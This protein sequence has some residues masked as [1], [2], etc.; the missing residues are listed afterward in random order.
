MRYLIHLA[1]VFLCTTSQLIYCEKFV[2]F[3]AQSKS[4]IYPILSVARELEKDNHSVTFVLS[5][6]MKAK[7]LKEGVNVSSITAQSLDT[8]DIVEKVGAVLESKA[9]GGKLSAFLNLL[10]AA[11]EQCHYFMVDTDL[12]T[13]LRYEKFDYAIVDYAHILCFEV[14]AYKLSLPFVYIG[15]HIDLAMYRT[16]FFPSFMPAFFS[17]FTDKMTFMERVMNVI[18]HMIHLSKPSM[19]TFDNVVDKYAPERPYLTNQQLRRNA[20]L[21]IIDGDVLMDYPVAIPPNIVLCGGLSASDAKS[22]PSNIQT[23]AESSNGIVIVSF[24]SI[25]KSIPQ[26]VFNKL[27]GSFQEVKQ[28]KFIFRYGNTE[29]LTENVLLLP[30]LPQNDLLGHPKT[31]LFI[32]HCGKSGLFEALYHGVPMIGFPMGM[33]QVPNAAVVVDK[34]YGISMDFKSFTTEDLV[35]NIKNVSFS[36][37]YRK[38]I[39]KA[40]EI[41]HS[42]PQKPPRRAAYWIDLVIRYGPRHF[43]PASMDMP[44]Y[45][46]YMLDVFL[47]FVIVIVLS[48]SVL[49]FV[50]KSLCRCCKKQRRQKLD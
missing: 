35:E 32:T 2:V 21:H 48:M 15:A 7:L 41:F 29:T 30:W 9:T 4:H 16:P 33:D 40:S 43:R 38:N 31:K 28:F 8:Y 23:F 1:V 26:E 37:D 6:S 47:F 11:Y 27:I 24:G 3:V 42:R 20:L 50:C 17:G 25:F 49:L 45:A 18:L 5:D 13:K 22:L 39:Q 19:P 10:K 12:Y 46:F 14:M 44:W 34:G 36:K